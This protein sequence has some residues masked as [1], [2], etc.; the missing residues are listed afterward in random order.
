MSLY[1]CPLPLP[2]PPLPNT[3]TR[4]AVQ[5]GVH[6][7]L[8]PA[9]HPPTHPPG[10]LVVVSAC[11]PLSRVWVAAVAPFDWVCSSTAAAYWIS[12]KQQLSLGA[13][14]GRL[15]PHSSSLASRRTPHTWATTSHHLLC[16]PPSSLH[17]CQV[18]R[19]T[20]TPCMCAPQED[21]VPKTTDNFKQL[22]ESR[23]PGFGYKGSPFHRVI[24]NF[25]CQ[26]GG[27]R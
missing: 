5:K 9:T 7:C 25:M 10:C 21:V 11:L 12:Y 15:T 23:N 6:V 2:P 3:S 8:P 22:C 17:F 27:N 24:P 19:P 1:P 16:H 14:S 4:A 26:V 13:H 20:S 18:T